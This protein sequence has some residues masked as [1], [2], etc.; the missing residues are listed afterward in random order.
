MEIFARRAAVNSPRK[1]LMIAVRKTTPRILKSPAK[2]SV[3]EQWLRSQLN[4]TTQIT[5]LSYCLIP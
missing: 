3:A 2:V 4:P 5:Q 1:I